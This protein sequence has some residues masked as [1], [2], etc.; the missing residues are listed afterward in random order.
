MCPSFLQ[1]NILHFI[2]CFCPIIKC[3]NKFYCPSIHISS[4]ITQSSTLKYSF[5]LLW[6]PFEMKSDV[7]LESDLL[8]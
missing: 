4:F 5:S 3:K 6:K 1:N 8:E 2:K 7:V